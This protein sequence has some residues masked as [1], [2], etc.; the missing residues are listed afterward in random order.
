MAL[1]LATPLILLPTVLLAGCW[2]ERP[3]ILQSTPVTMAPSGG[4]PPTSLDGKWTLS[5][6]GAGSCTMNFGAQPDATEG[7]IAAT[8]DCP[9]DFFTSR[10]WDYTAAGLVIRDQKAQV[11]AQLS[12]IGPDRFEGRTNDGQDVE[13]ARAPV[14]GPVVIRAQ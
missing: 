9:F 12:P 13:L 10:K 1:R 8:R 7:T 14:E 2:I 4:S 3:A 5:A 11:L 6:V